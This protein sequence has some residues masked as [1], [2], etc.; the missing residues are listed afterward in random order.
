MPCKMQHCFT[1]GVLLFMAE[2]LSHWN[3]FP[4]SQ[5]LYC[6]SVETTNSKISDLQAGF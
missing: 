6:P 4:H 5:S 2:L 3:N 1:D